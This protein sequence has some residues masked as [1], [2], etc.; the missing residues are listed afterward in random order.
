MPGQHVV[1]VQYSEQ[2]D[3]HTEFVYNGP[4]I[5]AQKVIWAND[6]GRSENEQLRRYY[7]NRTF[8]LFRPDEPTPKVILYPWD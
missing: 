8:W 4:D 7:P 3:P 1:F 2:H 5:D 6:L